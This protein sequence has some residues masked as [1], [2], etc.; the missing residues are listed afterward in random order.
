MG[1]LQPGS[2]SPKWQ[3]ER[4]RLQAGEAE[5][6]AQGAVVIAEEAVDTADGAVVIA[7]A[8][9][10]VADGA[11]TTAL[12]A[13]DVSEAFMPDLPPQTISADYTGAT[14]AGQLPRYIPVKR[15]QAGVDVTTEATWSAALLSGTAT[16]AIGA[17][18]GLFELSA[19]S[20]SSVFEITSVRGGVTLKRRQSFN[21]VLGTPPPSSGAGLFSA[22]DSSIL[23]SNSNAYVSSNAG[24]MT[25][26]CG[27]T[28]E[29]ELAAPL[30]MT[31]GGTEP[32]GSYFGYGV[33]QW[34]VVGGTWADV[35][36][37]TM[38]TANV[39]IYEE[40]IGSGQSVVID[41]EISI[42]ATKTG[43]TAGVDY[44]F[45]LQLRIDTLGTP[46]FLPL[47]AFVGTASAVTM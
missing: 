11:N 2:R 30:T 34:R 4:A 43:L 19:L 31:A 35:D 9:V 44:E 24:P 1:L 27:S 7:D 36:T 42:S 47:I 33:W 14:I 22:Y 21:R 28:G 23:P 13:K 39:T 16:G 46:P 38:S 15:F 29:V 18:T 10:V 41:G 32:V 25:I 26:E 17:A 37:E 6:T 20:S 8:A 12:Q 3:A 40:A 45:Q 5:D